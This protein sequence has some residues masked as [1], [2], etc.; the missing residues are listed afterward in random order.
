MFE[1]VFDRGFY[2]ASLYLPDDALIVRNILE[3]NILLCFIVKSDVSKEFILKNVTV[4]VYN[5]PL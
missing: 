2:E 5:H 3:Q 4:S 1:N